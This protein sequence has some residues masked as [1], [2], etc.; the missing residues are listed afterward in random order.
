MVVVLQHKKNARGNAYVPRH[1]I[2]CGGWADNEK[3]TSTNNKRN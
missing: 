1:T 2:G 3:E